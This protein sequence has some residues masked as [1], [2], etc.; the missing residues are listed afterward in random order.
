MRDQVYNYIKSL[1]L[2][3]ISL[4]AELPWDESGNSLYLK[5]MKRI[6]V[7]VA[8]YTTEPLILTLNKLAIDNEI[9]TVRVFL[10]VDAKKLSANYEKLIKKLRDGKA[11]PT[12]DNI[13][14]R[15]SNIATEFN[16]DMLVTTIEYRF[17]KLI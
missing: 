5:N 3:D 16:N 12:T 8:Q 14:F 11:I 6:Y 13:V 10:S 7:D 17:T 15:E 9:I 2:G 1:P 4:S